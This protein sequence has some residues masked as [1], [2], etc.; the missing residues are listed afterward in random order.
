MKKLCN[1]SVELFLTDDRLAFRWQ[2]VNVVEW[3][4]YARDT[5]AELLKELDREAGL[6]EEAYQDELHNQKN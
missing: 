6:L 2:W 1:I 5:Q 4:S 3:W